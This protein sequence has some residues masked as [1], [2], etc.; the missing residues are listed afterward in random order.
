MSQ[1]TSAVQAICGDEKGAQ[2]T[3][4]E[5][6]RALGGVV[7]SVP[8]VGHLKGAIHYAQGD[9]FGG[10][11]A[12]KSSSR[13]IGVIGGGVG[14]FFLLGPVG[15]FLGGVTSGVTIDAI[16][17]IVDSTVH[18]EFRPNGNIALMHEI[19]NGKANSAGHVFDL[20]F[21]MV[22]DGIAGNTA[23]RIANQ[24]AEMPAKHKK[25]IKISEKLIKLDRGKANIN[26]KL[27]GVAQSNLF[28]TSKTTV[29]PKNSH[30]TEPQTGPT[31]E[32]YSKDKRPHNA[33]ADV[34]FRKNQSQLENISIRNSD[35][36]SLS[37]RNF[38]NP[39]TTCIARL[40][41]CASCI[42]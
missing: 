10:D 17:T 7:D 20:T 30:L 16:T 34:L 8:I 13:S 9:K 32:S 21:G 42:F 22:L 11:N 1:I 27:D 15:A 33:R 19:R 3:Q 2:E 14:G 25:I 5:F 35:Q 38:R 39:K 28:L 23:G 26:N 40:P 12:M 24:I 41:R 29:T 4:L 37:T 18:D 36:N 31:T 6:L